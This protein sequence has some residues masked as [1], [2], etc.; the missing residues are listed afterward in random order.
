MQ[1]SI[2]ATDIGVCR[3]C[4]GLLSVEEACG[5]TMKRLTT[6]LLDL[7]DIRCQSIDVVQPSLTLVRACSCER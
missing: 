7:Q 3:W 5:E 6:D 1:C 2:I 4:L